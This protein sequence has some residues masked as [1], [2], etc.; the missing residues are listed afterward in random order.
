MLSAT[1][2][3]RF[4]TPCDSPASSWEITS[5]ALKWTAQLYSGKTLIAETDVIYVLNVICHDPVELELDHV[6]IDG[7]IITAKSDP[8]W[9]KIFEA[10]VERNHAR[11]VEIAGERQ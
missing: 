11:F 10:D 2:Y 3:D 5:F 7:T 4:H 1:S 6:E 8:V 9:F